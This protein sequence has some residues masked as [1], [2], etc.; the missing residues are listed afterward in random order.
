MDSETHAFVYEA[1]ADDLYCVG[2]TLRSLRAAGLAA[3][4]IGELT[5]RK[6]RKVLGSEHPILFLRAG[7]WLTDANNYVSPLPSASRKGLCA[8]GRVGSCTA[9]EAEV[10]AVE[11]A[12]TELLH[13]TGGDLS[14][15]SQ[16]RDNVTPFL[17]QPAA[18]FLD[19]VAVG[20]LADTGAASFRDI[21]ALAWQNF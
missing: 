9:H 8:L 13:R 4:W 5:E 17:I 7:T 20:Q 18:M 11:T 2:R 1:K 15:L 12:W 19:Q 10:A 3:T 6:F 14:R 21:A 16:L